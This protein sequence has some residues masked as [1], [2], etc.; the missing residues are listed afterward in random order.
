MKNHFLK[1][2]M[3]G[4]C[5]M[6]V[7]TMQA[8]MTQ[9]GQAHVVQ[10]SAKEKFEQNFIPP[11]DPD[12]IT[13]RQ[14]SNIAPEFFFSQF[15]DDIGLTADDEMRF[16]RENTD[17]FRMLHQRF[18]QYHKGYKVIG[19]EF[20][21]H[22]RNNRLET[23]NGK[24][25]RN[26]DGNT[27]VNV[28]ENT[29]LEQ[30][31]SIFPSRSFMWLNEKMEQLIKDNR[32]DPSATYF[33]SGELEW[34]WT[35]Y[36]TD[37]NQRQ[38]VLCYRFDIYCEKDLPQSV[39]VNASTNEIV[40]TLALAEDCGPGTG[41]STW[42]GTV[43][44]NTH[45]NLI[46]YGF[47]MWDDCGA[48][49]V[50]VRNAQG[51]NG[52]GNWIDY[53]DFDNTWNATDQQPVVQTY[54]GEI[55]AYS[56][57]Y[58]TFNRWSYDGNGSDI[59]GYNNITISN[60]S[61]NA[62]NNCYGTNE[63]S[64]GNG[65]T[66]ANNDNFN[67]VDIVGHEFTH[68]VTGTTS[69]LVYQNESGALNESCSDIFGEMTEIYAQGSADWLVGGQLSTGALRNFSNPNANTQPD[70]YLGTNW[71]SGTGCTPTSAN[72]F[73][74]V[75]TNSGVQN[76][77]F[78]LLCN[79]GSGTNDNGDAF[80]V[81][82]IGTPAAAWI[83]YYAYVNYMTSSS[84]YKDARQATILQANYGY[85]TC[86]DAA[87]AV[88]N[89]WYAVGVGTSLASYNWSV[90]GNYP[91]LFFN[92]QTSINTLDAANGCAVNINVSPTLVTFQSAHDIVLYPG[93][94]AYQGCNFQ[95][96]INPCSVNSLL[97]TAQV[98]SST[99]SNA[100]PPVIP[101]S[102]NASSGGDEFEISAL[103]NPAEEFVDVVINTSH[104]DDVTIDILNL[105]SQVQDKFRV[106]KYIST[107]ENKERL[108]IASLPQGVYLARVT[109]GKQMKT[110]RVV[111]M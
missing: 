1:I 13:A 16:V 104:E 85:G 62:C 42:N 79:G 11:S 86:S 44:L 53:T 43:N 32:H 89:A 28:A 78:Y 7:L 2:K 64:F 71:I 69:G 91:D 93:F 37:F 20:I 23:A 9:P 67:A 26:F 25:L 46:P 102:L 57:W 18:Q 88:G 58:S 87:I 60:S 65:S 77:W 92:T 80:S 27:R 55:M 15:G 24:L 49:G 99:S 21:L 8:Q 76:F 100:R 108:N 61:N 82:G 14:E 39:F 106:E 97:K 59:I 41:V 52:I 47:V 98:A 83:T 73:C 94:T 19:G 84:V 103:P 30:A 17:E 68:G 51:S 109:S 75:H 12:W 95:A 33:P 10:Q 110:V 50:I 35:E 36:K 4:A 48:P 31:E 70:T 38:F 74:G 5:L 72:D 101:G 45:F 90:C 96:I 6:L 63:L 81:S 40:N 56:Y 54:W 22:S 66:S 34:M 105:Q 111:K 3:L 107:G 29:A